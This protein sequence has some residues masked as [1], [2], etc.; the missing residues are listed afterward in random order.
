MC[1]CRLQF[2]D[3]TQTSLQRTRDDIV[4]VSKMCYKENCVKS[5]RCSFIRPISSHALCEYQN[6]SLN[7][8]LKRAI[9]RCR[10][11]PANWFKLS[12]ILS[13][14]LIA[15]LMGSDFCGLKVAAALKGKCFDWSQL[16]GNKLQLANKRQSWAFWLMKS[17]E[18]KE[19]VLL[20]YWFQ[21]QFE[22][23]LLRNLCLMSKKLLLKSLPGKSYMQKKGTYGKIVLNIF[24]TVVAALSKHYPKLLH[25]STQ[26]YRKVTG[27]WPK[28]MFVVIN[29]SICF[30]N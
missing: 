16:L 25:P 20:F 2:I 26:S 14:I 8:L 21:F 4:V 13:T 5:A 12:S 23:Q 28:I 24:I 10:S 18:S 6:T 19:T 27:Y 9:M 3:D 7:P 15:L 22:I 1:E 17:G 30:M 11:Y 29:Y